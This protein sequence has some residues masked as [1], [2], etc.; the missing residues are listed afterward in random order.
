M[1]RTLQGLWDNGKLILLYLCL[2]AM[3]ALVV[4]F[5]V[6][7]YDILFSDEPILGLA[8]PFSLLLAV[9]EIAVLVWTS[10]VI[11]NWP[12]ASRVLKGI[13]FILIPAFTFLC[14]TGINSYL[15][16][17]STAE[18]RKLH[19]VKV[20]NQNSDDYLLTRQREAISFQN[21][22]SQM[23]GE[24][25]TITQQINT[26]SLQIKSLSEQASERRLKAIDCSAVPDCAASVKAFEGQANLL[27]LEVNSLY[28]RR[29]RLD[30]RIVKL[31]ESLDLAL[32]DMTTIKRQN[33]ESINVHAGT[34]STFEMKKASYEKIILT[35][36]SW[37]GLAPKDPFSVFVGF[38][39]FLIYPVYFMLNLYVS[40]ESEPNKFVRAKS[41]T[42]R[43]KRQAETKKIKRARKS[44]RN[45]LLTKLVGY[46]RARILRLSR[47]A[48]KN[49]RL[50]QKTKARQKSQ[51]EVMYSKLIKYFRVWAHRRKKIKV[52]E[53]ERV[54]EI[55][56][57]VEK[58]VDRIVERE[59]V[60]EKEVEVIKEVPIEV[61]VE[62]P[63]EVDRIVEVPTEVPV[64]VEKIK[65]VPEPVFIKDP[66]IVIHE[67][68]I[69]VPENITGEELERLLNAQPRLNETAR[70]AESQ[71]Y[72][73]SNDITD[74]NG[75]NE[76]QRS[77]TE[78]SSEKADTR[79]SA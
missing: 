10:A 3:G 16:T 35:V 62:V 76:S 48:G 52:N 46:Q 43:E 49:F 38:V 68:I 26:A 30:S 17:L 31:E 18:I 9:A 55:E 78:R 14:F 75:A 59:I 23:R 73:A 60:V 54:V 65:K 7:G 36:T 58:E 5:N 20:Q 12:N 29:A 77:V 15:N 1:K 74:D 4:T 24:R 79:I 71:L 63:V 13:L 37:F 61:R 44:L 42:E 39:S 22:V 32:N 67:R 69:P 6:K 50:R 25:E 28:E 21:Q 53:V 19:E 47:H 27:T 33:T 2:F 11:A 70:T 72:S 66:Q 57:V 34:E 64:F 56:K 40:L 41:R 8:S 45:L 51:R